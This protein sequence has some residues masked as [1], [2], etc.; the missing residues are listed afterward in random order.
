V[1]VY[2]AG[3]SERQGLGKLQ[4][5]IWKSNIHI[6]LSHASISHN[7]RGHQVLQVAS[8]FIGYFFIQL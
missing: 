3:R 2:E 4:H 8:L 6:S 5:L 7:T 1:G